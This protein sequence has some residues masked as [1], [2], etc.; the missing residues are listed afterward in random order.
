VNDPTIEVGVALVVV[1]LAFAVVRD[2]W[3]ALRGAAGGQTAHWVDASR[4][5]R[6]RGRRLGPGAP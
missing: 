4:A 3:C 1:G 2:A 5:V 6:L